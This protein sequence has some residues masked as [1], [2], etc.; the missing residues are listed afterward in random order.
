MSDEAVTVSPAD[1]VIDPSPSEHTVA[2]KLL[3]KAATVSAADTVLVLYQFGASA[4]SVSAADTERR[5]DPEETE[6]PCGRS[7]DQSPKG[8]QIVPLGRGGRAVPPVAVAGCAGSAGL[9]PPWRACSP[10]AFRRHPPTLSPGKK[11]PSRA[12]GGGSRQFL[13]AG[14][15][16]RKGWVNRT[17]SALP[18]ARLRAV[19]KGRRLRLSTPGAQGAGLRLLRSQSAY[20][21]IGP[22]YIASMS[23]R[24]RSECISISHVYRRKLNGPYGRFQKKRRN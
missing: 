9:D 4:S 20:V 10:P 14:W 8:G 18:T 3:K 17:H 1:T 5:N 12:D 23:F 2:D 6:R 15:G 24:Y 22:A 13:F 7:V 16:E 21:A 11:G 19:D